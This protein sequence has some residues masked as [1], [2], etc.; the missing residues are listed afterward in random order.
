MGSPRQEYWS[1]LPF[2][3]QGVLPDPEVE[4]ASPALTGGFFTTDA[5]GNFL[6]QVSKMIPIKNTYKIKFKKRHPLMLKYLT[7]NPLRRIR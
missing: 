1:G 5:P 4:P 7:Q 6:L 2:P 3:P